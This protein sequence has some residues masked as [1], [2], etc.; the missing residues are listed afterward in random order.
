MYKNVG[1]NHYIKQNNTDSERQTPYISHVQNFKVV[2][3]YVTVCVCL[4]MCVSI[5]L[6]ICPCLY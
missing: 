5:S 2:Y 4:Y 1:R 6:F 3:M